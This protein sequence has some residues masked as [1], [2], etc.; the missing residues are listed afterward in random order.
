MTRTLEG[1]V[2]IVTGGA[3]G[4]GEAIVRRLAS[5]G[6]RV[7]FTYSKSTEE[8]RVL[9]TELRAG[10]ADVLAIEADSGNVEVAYLANRESSFITG[11]AL[12]VDGGFLA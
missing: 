7:A 4:I 10:G 8:A 3:R 5:E 9:E 2:A 1:R 11:A 12:T 6:A